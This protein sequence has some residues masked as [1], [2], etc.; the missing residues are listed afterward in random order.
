MLGF[1]ETSQGVLDDDDGTIHDQ[2]EIER[3]EAHQ[4]GRDACLQHA[5]AGEQHRDRDDESR[6]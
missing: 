2:A 1:G 5:D 4:I 6:D 3:A